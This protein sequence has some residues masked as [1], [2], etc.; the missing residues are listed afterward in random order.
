[1]EKLELYRSA[2]IDIRKNLL[3]S[4]GFRITAFCK[5]R[6]LSAN[7]RKAL[8]RLKVIQVYKNGPYDISQKYHL[9][10]YEGD[11]VNDSLVEDVIADLKLINHEQEE[12][13]RRNY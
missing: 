3:M 7:T 1:M 5:L 6:G 4:K 10:I 11:E 8:L 13:R 12:W 9:W 2:L